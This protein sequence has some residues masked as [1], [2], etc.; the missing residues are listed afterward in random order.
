MRFMMIVKANKD[1]EAGVPPSPELMAAIG[2]LTEEGIKSGALLHNGGLLPSS[3]GARI[4]VGGGKLTVID[5]PFAE[6]KELVGGFAILQAKSREEAIEMG[7]NFMKVHA[8]VLGPSYEGEL[9]VRQMFEPG[10]FASGQ[11]GNG[12]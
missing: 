11:C 10:D 3:K 1:Y 9:E 5:G 7:A 12:H 2:K 4:R 8:D 6:T